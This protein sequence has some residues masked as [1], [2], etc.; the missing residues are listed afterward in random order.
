MFAGHFGLAAGVRAQAQEVP[1][2]ALMLATQLL[3]VAFIPFLLTG[4][5]TMEGEPGSGYGDWIIHA[6]YTHSLLGALM[7]AS[8]AGMLAKRM[9]GVRAG[10]TIGAVTFSHWL[11]DLIVHRADMPLLPGNIGHLPL[12]GL[13]AWKVEGVSVAL[14]LILIVAGLALYTRSVVKASGSGKRKTAYLSSAVLGVLLVLSLVTDVAGL[15]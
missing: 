5:E 1:L 11:L 13:G 2:W 7:I 9:W 3:D 10:R 8:L 6:D 15:F 4:A 12:L 14:E